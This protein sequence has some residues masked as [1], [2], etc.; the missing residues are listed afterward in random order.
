MTARP[1]RRILIVSYYYPPRAIIG[2][3]RPAALAKYLTRDGHE[4]TVLTSPVNGLEPSAGPGREIRAR[5]LLT[6]RLNWR[7]AKA[8]GTSTGSGDVTF[9][10]AGLWGSLFVPDV[11][12][13]SWAPFAT[14]AALRHARRWR[15]DVVVTTSPVESAH[16]VGLALKRI[17][18]V[19]WVVDLRDGWRFE[20][21][22]DEW[23]TT[24]QR[25]LDDALERTVLT[26]AD[27]VV[28][29]SEPL[30]ADLRRRLD[31]SITTVSNGFDPDDLR[32]DAELP[33]GT[34]DPNRLTLVHTGGLGSQ[35]T[36]APIIEALC[37]LRR[38]DPASAARFQLLVAGAQTD[39]ERRLYGADGL[40]DLV[41]PLG[42]LP[43]AQALAL[44]RR[45]DVLLLVTSGVRTGEAT[46]KL[47]EYLAAR[48]P[49]LVL[50]DNSEAARIVA[51]S[52]SGWAIPVR[53]PHAA[54]RAL[55]Q[56]IDNAHARPEAGASERFAY[57]S[58]TARYLE[59]IDDVIAD[60]R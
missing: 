28:T 42:M 15:P 11:Q 35:R 26:A 43:R 56:I 12:L 51:E 55:R 59:L 7:R 14:V 30:S 36:L 23:P 19:P 50:G 58:L 37:A 49:I 53:D 2:A 13:L 4:V 29:V 41:R 20:A 10:G 45:A 21:P 46:G 3:R 40:G 18:G 31:L 27:R 52:H 38:E 47:F 39:A 9:Q 22:R 57:P 1:Q 25:S 24:L 5:D 6:S 60:R 54:L 16:L 32:S 33:A 48:R 8:L 34:V 44:Q 17:L